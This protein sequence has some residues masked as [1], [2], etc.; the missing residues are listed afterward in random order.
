[1]ISFGSGFANETVSLNTNYFQNLDSIQNYLTGE[2]T[3]V[4]C[5]DYLAR[6][7]NFYY[8]TVNVTSY[9]I[10]AP[11]TGT[12]SSVIQN[13]LSNLPVGGIFIMSDMVTQLRLNGI[14]NIQNPPVVTYTKYTRDLTTPITGTIVDVLDP[15]D[16]TNVFLLNTVNTYTANV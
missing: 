5:G 14:T 8:L 10:S 15:N 9:N 4:L 12:V 13:Y 7:F 3:R 11:D 1:M 6:G 16:D 2:N